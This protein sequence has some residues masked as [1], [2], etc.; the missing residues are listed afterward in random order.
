MSHYNKQ[1]LLQSKYKDMDLS[2]LTI[3]STFMH[4]L[5]PK[6]SKQAVPRKRFGTGVTG[7]GF[8]SNETKKKTAQNE[9]T[10]C[11]TKC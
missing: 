7:C 1:Q 11:D 9:Y 5:I 3:L 10:C 6:Y 8:A 4:G 2:K